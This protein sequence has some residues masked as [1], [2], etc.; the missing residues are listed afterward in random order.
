MRR[1]PF[2]R[3]SNS[4]SCAFASRPSRYM[5]S[6]STGSHT[7]SGASSSRTHS[8]AQA[9]LRSARLKYATSGPV[10]AITA[11]GTAEALE[12]LRIG[13]EVGDARID[14]AA[15]RGHQFLEARA[16]ALAA[17][18]LQHEPQS[19]L[20]Q[21]LE[22]AAAQ[23]RLG[24]GAAEQL[25]GQLDGGLHGGLSG[26]GYGNPYYWFPIPASTTAPRAA[27]YDPGSELSKPIS[28]A[29]AHA[30]PT[31]AVPLPRPM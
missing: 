7:R 2:S 27:N 8:T 1:A 29:A 13:P 21:V 4:A 28:A 6:A 14:D 12:M 23:R 20:N 3:S 5:T 10:S 31:A 22:L 24:L 15:R 18:S 19:L 11:P 16:L 9:W 30:S 26:I 17:R 25:L